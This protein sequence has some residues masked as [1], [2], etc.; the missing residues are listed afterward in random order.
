[1]YEEGKDFILIIPRASAA[2]EKEA[3]E[4]RFPRALKSRCCAGGR[5]Y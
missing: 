4:K 5:E 3:G 1:M 2:V